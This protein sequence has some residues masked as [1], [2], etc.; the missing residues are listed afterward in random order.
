MSDDGGQSE[1]GMEQCEYRDCDAI[2]V[3][4][5][6]VQVPDSGTYDPSFCDTH[7]RS[8]QTATDQ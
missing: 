8:I 4:K 7:A 6:A 3:R 5:V 1:D 2:A